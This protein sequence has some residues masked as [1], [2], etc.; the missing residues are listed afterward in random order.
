MNSGAWWSMVYRIKKCRTQL[1][2]LTC[3]HTAV[4]IIYA[5]EFKPGNKDS[6]DNII[7][8]C[9]CSGLPKDPTKHMDIISNCWLKI[10]FKK[11]TFL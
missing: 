9:D 7:N 10:L 5:Y 4:T 3:T 8:L 2:Q 11:N 1:K 6:I